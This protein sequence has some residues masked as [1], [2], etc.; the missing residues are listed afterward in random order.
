M[1]HMPEGRLK[2][3]VEEAEKVRALKEVSKANLREQGAALATF[4]RRAEEAKR[5]YAAIKKRAAD[6]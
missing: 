1:T 3:A 5:A 2:G 6:L 4:E